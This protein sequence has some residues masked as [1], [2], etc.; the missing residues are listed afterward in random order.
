[1]ELELVLGIAGAVGAL[2]SAV[3]TV[4]M[5]CRKLDTIMAQIRDDVKA[6]RDR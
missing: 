3:V 2:I 4:V 1:M 6:I 5:W